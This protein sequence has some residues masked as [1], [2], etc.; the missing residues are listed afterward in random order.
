MSNSKP[1]DNFSCR[2]Y[3]LLLNLIG[4]YL[5]SM[6]FVNLI[7]IINRDYVTFFDKAH[8]LLSIYNML[9]LGLL[10]LSNIGSSS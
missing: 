1:S 3:L 4:I 5:F 6:S 2:K 7:I 9:F 10:I 8:S